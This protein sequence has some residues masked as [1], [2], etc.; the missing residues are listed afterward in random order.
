[1]PKEKPELPDFVVFA[2]VYSEQKGF[3]LKNDGKRIRIG[4]AKKIEHSEGGIQIDLEA[5][6]LANSLQLWPYKEKKK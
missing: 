3:I 4:T 1:M 6:P 5:S 2:P